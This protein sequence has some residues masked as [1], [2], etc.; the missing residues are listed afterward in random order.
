VGDRV[1]IVA[2]VIAI[3]V[4]SPVDRADDGAEMQARRRRVGFREDVLTCQA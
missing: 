1:R 3:G 4:R 2:K